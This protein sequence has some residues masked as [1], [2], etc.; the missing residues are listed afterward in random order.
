[1]TDSSEIKELCWGVFEQNEEAYE[2]MAAHLFYCRQ[3]KYKERFLA[4]EREVLSGAQFS[5]WAGQLETRIVTGSKGDNPHV[6]LDIRRLSWPEGLWV[7]AYKHTWLAVFPYCMAKDIEAVS[8]R[9]GTFCAPAVEVPAWPGHW[10]ASRRFHEKSERAVNEKG[11][12]AL[13]C[14]LK[15]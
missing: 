6:F 8:A 4:L 5:D 9:L 1:M 11:N 14:R 13:N 7:K 12:S 15:P 2:R 10:F 3:R